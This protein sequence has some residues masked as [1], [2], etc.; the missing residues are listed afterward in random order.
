VKVTPNDARADHPSK[1]PIE[2]IETGLKD[3]VTLRKKGAT[4]MYTPIFKEMLATF[5]QISRGNAMVFASGATSKQTLNESVYALIEAPAEELVQK[6]LCK[7]TATQLGHYLAYLILKSE[8]SHPTTKLKSSSSQNIESSTS[9]DPLERVGNGLNE[10]IVLG[11]KGAS[12]RYTPIFKEMLAS[13]FEIRRG[14]AL[15]FKSGAQ[16]SKNDSIRA[17]VDSKAE[18]LVKKP[19]GR[20]TAT[21]LGHYVAYLLITSGS[22]DKTTK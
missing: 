22:A 11:V 12:K 9:A 13:L 8:T 7:C 18:D 5:F 20:C 2:V 3:I 15:V 21:Q 6:P 10:I 14:N 17:I 1:T 16:Q 4:K 19:L